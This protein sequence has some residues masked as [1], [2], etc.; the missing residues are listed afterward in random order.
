MF[1]KPSCSS[2]WV[3]VNGSKKFS[4]PG[5]ISGRPGLT[6]RPGGVH[7]R[8][9]QTNDRSRRK[10]LM[11]KPVSVLGT[12]L[13]ARRH[14]ERG[15]RGKRHPAPPGHRPGRDGGPAEPDRRLRSTVLNYA[16]GT[17][18]DAPLALPV[19]SR[20]PPASTSTQP[21]LRIQTTSA[22]TTTSS[23]TTPAAGRPGRRSSRSATC[24]RAS[25]RT[26]PTTL[27][28]SSTRPAAR[29]HVRGSGGHQVG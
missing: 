10:G 4:S 24:C 3:R 15:R 27:G 17:P 25:R 19:S 22:A 28:T 20:P 14:S 18:A 29:H 13:M 16:T 1:V 23:S 7:I 21:S 9:I 5:G 6:G 8:R 12:G 2:A 26:S 11:D